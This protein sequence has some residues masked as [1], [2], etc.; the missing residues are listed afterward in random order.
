MTPFV[1]NG[2]GPNQACTLY[3]SNGGQ[4]HISG[5]AYIDAGYDIHSADLWRRNLLVLLG[6]LVLFQVTQV[7]ALDY[8]PVSSSFA[9][10]CRF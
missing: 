2:L 4:D 3:G 9:L 7:V 5:E 6:F 1:S 8:F 10:S